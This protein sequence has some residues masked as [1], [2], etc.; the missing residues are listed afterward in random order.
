MRARQSGDSRRRERKG[1]TQ[2]AAKRLEIYFEIMPYKVFSIPL[3]DAADRCE[4]LN[5]FL[6]SHRILQTERQFSASDGG[7]WTIL[8]EYVD[9][10]PAD[11]A[12]VSRRE[13]KDVTLDM[14]EPVRQPHMCA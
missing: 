6:R 11:T 14:P 2:T 10:Q 12:A 4:E 1:R 7:Y 5:K 9:G 3:S 8:V 13:R